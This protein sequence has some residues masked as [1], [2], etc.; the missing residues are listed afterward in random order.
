MTPE[1]LELEANTPGWL[2]PG[3]GEMLAKYAQDRFC[4]EI[5]SYCGKSTLWIASTALHVVSIDPHRG[6]PEMAPGRECHHPDVWDDEI[7]AVDSTPAL[8]RTLRRS[9]LEPKVSVVAA[10]SG[11]VAGWWNQH[12]GFLFIDGS[13]DAPDPVLDF[14]DWHSHV[15]GFIAFHDTPIP[16]V[17]DACRAALAAGWQLVDSVASLKVFGR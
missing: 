2:H 6:N 13:H 10:P 4:V 15:N 14:N 12:I 17:A 11:T 9:G 16:A 1:L 3:E 7:G 5:G 8:R